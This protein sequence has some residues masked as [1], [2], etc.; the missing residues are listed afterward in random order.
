MNYAIN[1][2]FGYKNFEIQIVGTGAAFFQTPMT[3]S[4]FWNGWGDGNYSAF[5]R[6][7]IGGDY[8]RL[9]YTKSSNNFVQSDFWLRDGGWFK[10]Q[11][12]ELAYTLPFK[13]NNKVGIR[14]I[15]FSL[16]GQNLATISKIKDVDPESIDAGVTGYPLFRIITAGIKFNF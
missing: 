15:R 14:N 13:Q 8:P 11:D 16:K 7:N 6:D 9:A 12:V 10:I 2:G 4:Y 3:N 1:L 5:V